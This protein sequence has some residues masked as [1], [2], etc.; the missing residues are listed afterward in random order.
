MCPTIQPKPRL[1]L[2]MRLALV[3]AI[4]RAVASSSQ[5]SD[6][7]LHPPQAAECAY[8]AKLGHCFNQSGFM[9]RWCRSA[10]EQY[11]LRSCDAYVD[12]DDEESAD[13]LFF[14][15]EAA[16]GL[17]TIRFLLDPLSLEPETLAAHGLELWQGFAKDNADIWPAELAT[18]SALAHAPAWRGW[19]PS[20]TKPPAT[21]PLERS[22]AGVLIMSDAV[23]TFEGFVLSK[24]GALVSGYQAQTL[25]LLP[26][27]L[28]MRDSY[29]LS[30]HC[31]QQDDLCGCCLAARSGDE[32]A[33]VSLR[34]LWHSKAAYGAAGGVAASVGVDGSTQRMGGPVGPDESLFY[35]ELNLYSDLLS[36]CPMAP[37]QQDA[38]VPSTVT[39]KRLIVFQT[40]FGNK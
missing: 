25:G 4:N 10:C 16:D 18:P 31:P 8:W 22:T 26:E 40:L 32:A 27:L 34:Q 13:D 14:D 3:L 2:Q 1:A 20:C 30:R 24:S 15:S 35:D 5:G 23:V 36:R 33:R 17:P 9:D 29:R 21:M 19:N 38:A 11:S 39:V 37:G 12:L 6:G 28:S 7:S